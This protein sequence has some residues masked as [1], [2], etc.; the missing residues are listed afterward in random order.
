MLLLLFFQI[1]EKRIYRALQLFGA[2]HSGLL[3][4]D[5]IEEKFRR[6]L[7][8][9]EKKKQSDLIKDTTQMFIVGAVLIATVAFGATFA[10]PG[11]YKADDHL[12]GG[13]PTLAGSY[14]FDAFMMAN[15][16]AFSCSAVGTLALVLSG[17]TMVDMGFRQFNLAA[18][19]FL[20]SSA[21][22]SMSL[23]FALAVFM[24]LAPVTRSTAIAI[25]MISPLPVLYRNVELI[26]KWGLLLRARFVRRGVIAVVNSFISM[27]IGLILMDLW[28]VVV[29][30][31]WA[32]FARIHH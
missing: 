19:V 20:M 14:I 26:F 13:T 21:V 5:Q 7:N 32:G 6:P 17:T 23:A 24:V 11:G 2:K 22:T 9:K 27:V 25:F 30:F 28:P 15:T 10:I 4:C 16:L 3:R 8:Q 12:N 18:A 31:A 29:T 1:S